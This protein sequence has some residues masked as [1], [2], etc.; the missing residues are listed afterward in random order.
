VRDHR[1][2]P[3]A[4][5]TEPIRTNMPGGRRLSP[6][7]VGALHTAAR[8]LMLACAQQIAADA[9]SKQSKISAHVSVAIAAGT[10]KVIE[11]VPVV[12]EVSAP[13]ADAEQCVRDRIVGLEVS[14]GEE[15]DLERYEIALSYLMAS[16]AGQ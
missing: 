8:P 13:T 6:A 11:V 2:N 9:R 16:P 1:K 14:A 15:E 3:G 7:T 5:P 4:A 12:A 10:M